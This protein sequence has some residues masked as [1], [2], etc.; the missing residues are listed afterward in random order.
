MSDTTDLIEE[1]NE[2]LDKDPV[3]PNADVEMHGC[4]VD[5]CRVY[6]H[7]RLGAERHLATEH[8]SRR[9]RISDYP[10]GEESR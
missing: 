10:R 8:D 6:K 4:P 1:A 3:L 9:E 5:G 2:L 7:T